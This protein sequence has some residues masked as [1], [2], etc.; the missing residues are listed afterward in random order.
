MAPLLRFRDK[1]PP[2]SPRPLYQTI[3]LHSVNLEASNV[4]ADHLCTLCYY[5]HALPLSSVPY[6][7][8]VTINVILP[9][10]GLQVPVVALLRSSTGTHSVFYDLHKPIRLPKMPQPLRQTMPSP[11]KPHFFLAGADGALGGL[12]AATGAAATGAL[13]AEGAAAAGAAAVG[14]EGAAALGA[15]GAATVGAEGG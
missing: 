9:D 1:V 3:L 13:G 15:L 12:G 10:I 6:Q 8:R 7:V 2:A 14:A 11:S 5:A 4:Q